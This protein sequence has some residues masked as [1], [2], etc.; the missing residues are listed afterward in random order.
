[1]FSKLRMT[2]LSTFA[3]S[4]LQEGNAQA[5]GSGTTTRYWD[6]CK[7]SCGYTGKAPV[8][9]PIA[10][11]DINDSPLTDVDA[12]SGCIGGPAYMCSDQSP[13]AVDDDLAYG[14]SA[15]NI[16]GGDESTWC[17]ACYKYFISL[18][19]IRFS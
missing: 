3:I 17:C 4:L 11:C 14:F 10:T 13:W 5:S 18:T 7:G 15:V 12:E 1:M 19:F 16:V 9:S 6:C 8:S 2:V